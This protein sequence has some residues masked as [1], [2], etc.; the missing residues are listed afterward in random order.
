MQ[1]ENATK[2]ISQGKT[3]KSYSLKYQCSSTFSSRSVAEMLPNLPH[4]KQVERTD[5]SCRPSL[6]TPPPFS[7]AV[8][9]SMNF[10]AR[11]I[12]NEFV[13]GYRTFPERRCCV[14][15]SAVPRPRTV[16]T[17]GA[18]IR[19]ELGE[20]QPL[21]LLPADGDRRSHPSG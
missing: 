14:S 12:S 19:V 2:M 18:F 20:R 13:Y 8:V 15:L 4:G 6:K 17:R 7:M 5:R 1:T 3:V 16:G 9:V 10:G 11:G 21:S